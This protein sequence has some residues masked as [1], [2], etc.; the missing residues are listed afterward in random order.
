MKAECAGEEGEPSW[1]TTEGCSA[2]IVAAEEA[3]QAATAELE[4]LEGSD[5]C[6]LLLLQ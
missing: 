3:H 6:L 5:D 4:K 1:S 2:D